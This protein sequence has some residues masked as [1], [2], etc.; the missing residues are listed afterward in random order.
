ML[1]QQRQKSMRFLPF[2][3]GGAWTRQQVDVFARENPPDVR[4]VARLVPLGAP[5][6]LSTCH[7]AGWE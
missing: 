6:A 4:L 5:G 3:Q 1:F 2:Q 7:N